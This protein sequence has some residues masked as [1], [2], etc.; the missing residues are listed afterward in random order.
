[1]D[2]KRNK[3]VLVTGATGYVGSRLVRLL[4][5][6][7]YRVRAT[8]RSLEKIRAHQDVTHPHLEAMEADLQ[9]FNSFN[10]ATKGCYAAYFLVHSLDSGKNFASLDRRAALNMVRAAESSNMER[11]IYLGGIGGEKDSV[12]EHL[13]SRYEVGKILKSG[14]VPV[15][16]LRAAIILGSG[17]ASF[18]IIRYVADRMPVIIA[19]ELIHT[20]CQPICIRNV[21]WYLLGCLESQKTI[22]HTYDIGG[23][24]IISYADL[25]NLY[26]ECAGLKNRRIV[27]NPFI[28]LELLAYWINLICPVPKPLVS[29]LIEG[30]GDE[31]VC[32]ENRIREIIPQSLMNCEQAIKRALEKIEQQIVDSFY[33][34]AGIVSQ[35]EWMDK[36]DEPYSG[37]SVLS[38]SYRICVKA[39]VEQVW[40][41]IKNIGGEKGWYFAG[42]L[43]WLRGFMDNL[44]GGVGIQRGRR[45]P[46]RIA[47]GDILDCWRVLD[48]KL[49]RRILLLAELKLPGEAILEFYL[50]DSGENITDLTMNAKFLAKGL[51]GLAYW[52]SVSPLHDYVFKG[53]LS[54]IA[55]TCRAQVVSGPSRL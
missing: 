9:D 21:L 20:K 40:G 35:P 7:G 11:I 18:E 38:C 51:S 15:T 13:T 22:G 48:V 52:Y 25:I 39:P 30:L 4:L 1:M 44:V 23:P 14:S 27:I 8:A 5:K 33:Y 31:V 32:S 55:K 54:N 47:V 2:L 17:S 10:L 19:P 6:N 12:S 41:P 24:D 3:P 45:H 53:M 36:G 37:G 26:S 46:S 43:W 50:T 28:N 42:R 16:F 49:H 29:A 34:D